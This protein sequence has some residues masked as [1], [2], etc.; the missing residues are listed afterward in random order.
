MSNKT[1]LITDAG[2]RIGAAIARYLHTQAMDIVIH[3]NCSATEAKTLAEELN[4]ERPNSAMS[5]QGN[6]LDMQAINNTVEKAYQFKNKMDT[7]INNA[8]SFFPSQVSETTEE[9]WEKLIGI[10]MKPP[11]FPGK[12]DADMSGES[13]G[14]YR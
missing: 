11:F 12:M 3:Y 7:L 13:T 14:L 10:N 9:H 1:I 8:S 6:L 5:V 4:S 2:Q